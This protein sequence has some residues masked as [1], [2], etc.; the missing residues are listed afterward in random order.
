[1]AGIVALVVTLVMRGVAVEAQPTKNAP[2]IGVVGAPEEPRF[3]E[4]VAGLKKGLGELGYSFKT[5][6]ILEV[7]VA[8]ADEASA[9]S[10]VQDL[11]RQRV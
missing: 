5:A 7:K 8:R 4:I 6:Q 3:S 1:L 11:L 9:K 2:I 10:I